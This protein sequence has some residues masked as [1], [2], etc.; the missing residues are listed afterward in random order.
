MIGKPISVLAATDRADEMP[1]ILQEIKRG[2]R[3]EHYETVRRTKDERLIMIS[4]TVSPLHDVEGRV[5]GASKI[6]RDITER[7]MAEEEL[8]R[9]ADT[10]A[11]AERAQD[12]PSPAKGERRAARPVTGK[13][14]LV[15]S[16]E[17]ELNFNLSTLGWR[18]NMLHTSYHHELV[19]A[20]LDADHRAVRKSRHCFQLHFRY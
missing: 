13:R 18:S 15:P 9:Q 8:A 20:L 10:P 14:L 3:I 11:F 19:R 4:L 7:K 16:D 2:K 6:A 5:V 12:G 1:N 17:S